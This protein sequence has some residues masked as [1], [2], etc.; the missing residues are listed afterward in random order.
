MEN[1]EGVELNEEQ[2]LCLYIDTKKYQK[3]LGVCFYNYL[4]YE[5]LMTEFI[6]NG[7]FTAL[8]SLFIQKRPYKCFFNSMNDLVDDERLLNLFKMCNIEAVALERKKY[9]V[10]N[11]KEE[12][13]LIIPQNDDVRNYDKHL[14]LENACKCLMV[15]INHLKVKENK[16]IH[17][18]CSINIHNMDLY[19]RL[20]KAAISA[21]NILP[22]KK[23]TNS[24]SNNTSLLKFLNKCNTTIGCKKLMSWLTQ[25]LTSVSEINKRLNIVET[26]IE[27][28]DL[29]N[30][31]YC[32]YL[33]RIPE[34]DK[35]NHYLKEINQNNE[36]KGN[37]KYNEEMIL[38]DIVKLYYAILDFKQIYFS[39][40]SI[41]GKHKQTVIE[42]VVNP[43][44]EILNNF[45]KLLDMIE[46][47]IDL[48]EIEENKVYLISKNFDEELEEISNEKNALMK[49]IKRHK[50]DVERDLF[51]DKCDRRYK[52]TNR[53]DIRLVD[54]NTNVFLF[55]VSKKDSTIIQHQKKCISVRMNKNEFLFTTSTLKGLCKQYEHCLNIYNTL[56]LEIVKKTICA[57]S[58][59]TPVI[60]KFIDVVST[61]DVLVSFAVVCYNSP[62]PYV[63]PTVV[64]DGEN[65]IMKKSRHPLLELQHNLSN[66]IPNDIHMNKKESRLIIVTGP[67][68]GGKSTYIRQTA[69]ICILAQIGMFVPC[70]FCEIP[71]FSQVMCRVGA[72]DFQLKGI[73]TFL[74]EMIEASAIVKNADKNSFIIVDE[75]GRGTSTYEGLGI[76]WSI[77]KYILDH[78][79]CFC[80]FATHFH[81]ISNIAYQCEGV[82]NRHVET[83]IDQKQKKICFLYE[84]KDGA[85]NKSYGVNVAEIAKLPKD[86]IQRA[87]EKVEELESAE[88]KYYLKEKLNIDTSSST[89]ENYKNKISNYMKIKDEINYLFS[90]SSES[91]FMDR[92]M[93]K[94]SYLKEFAI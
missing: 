27:E 24:Y 10:S 11:L 71:V 92:F 93:S 60:E 44:H 84:I 64:E 61:L 15:L 33:K 74:S 77:G 87:Y 82:I 68:M 63:R 57:V 69:I 18:Q 17:Y 56:Q 73:S 2:I 3:T 85:S 49:K 16:D 80:L 54:C 35:L 52:R 81:E 1:G 90:S 39:L 30:S 70:D 41:E 58:T 29:R 83:T 31:V 88:N 40:V 37:S 6:D 21:L 43:L 36:I 89:N 62:F 45:S 7:Y 59:Y 48:K 66:F 34:L 26:F 46:M 50:E 76:S 42:M 65:V 78:I 72:S 38:K 47:T 79:K 51:S 94:K 20:D 28:D 32:N 55:R 67:N 19:M 5:F 86:V 75:L 13:K 9:D 23:N 14:E 25:P 91:E 8:E 4:K 53:E 12:L 22:N